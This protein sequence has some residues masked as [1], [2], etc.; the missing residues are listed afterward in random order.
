MF[1]RLSNLNDNSQN[2]FFKL[3][4]PASISIAEYGGRRTDPVKKGG[5]TE[6]NCFGSPA[7]LSLACIS[8]SARN[9]LSREYSYCAIRGI[10][11]SMVYSALNTSMTGGEDRSSKKPWI[12]VSTRVAMR[13]PAASAKFR[14][15][16]FCQAT[17]VTQTKHTT[18]VARPNHTAVS[19][20]R[21][22]AGHMT[23]SWC[24][25]VHSARRR[26]VRVRA[27]SP[28]S[29]AAALR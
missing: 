1:N 16:A 7:S 3:I 22:L 10:E 6:L 25:A 12:A 14:D 29:I 24:E 2:G 8:N 28:A 11:R 21:T 27:L 17:K 5:G 4:D 18:P 15:L 13:V 19:L 20:R 26:A 9:P 23:K